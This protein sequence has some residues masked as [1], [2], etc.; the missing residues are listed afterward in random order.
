MDTNSIVITGLIAGIV[1]ALSR[2]WAD[3]IQ[4]LFIKLFGQQDDDFYANL[5]FAL[6]VTAIVFM[7]KIII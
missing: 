6:F 7:L 2:A 4:Q 3:T 1:L 5:F